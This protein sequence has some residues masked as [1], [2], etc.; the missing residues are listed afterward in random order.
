MNNLKEYILEKFK[1]SK[2]INIKNEIEKD[3]KFLFIHLYLDRVPSLKG[4]QLRVTE[5]ILTCLEITDDKFT[6]TTDWGHEQTESYIIND[7]GHI[8]LNSYEKE[9]GL[10]FS[11]SSGILF[12]K[13]VLKNKMSYKL[14]S[15]YLDSNDKW[16]RDYSINYN[17]WEEGINKLI[18][19]LE[20]IK[21]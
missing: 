7:T 1:I 20:K 21:N 10:C 9:I 19:K 14:L 6:F 17:Y 2:D 15:E 18:S 3:D 13:D 11:P 5:E 16:I 4:P 8:E 12:L